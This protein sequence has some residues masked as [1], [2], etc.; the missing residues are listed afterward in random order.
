[1]KEKAFDYQ[2]GKLKDDDK[3]DE[4]GKNVVVK[5]PSVIG[6]DPVYLGFSNTA[7]LAGK[8]PFQ[9]D[10]MQ[11]LDSILYKMYKSGEIEKIM[12]QFKE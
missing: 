10:F 9:N 8:Y 4:G 2:F 11:E 6:T 1:M 12:A 5:K 7:R 3:Y